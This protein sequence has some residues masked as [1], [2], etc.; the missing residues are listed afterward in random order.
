MNWSTIT[1]TAAL[2]ALSLAP[3]AQAAPA[4]T[5]AFTATVTNPSDNVGHTAYTVGQ[6]VSGE[7]T[8]YPTDCSSGTCIGGATLASL[9]G[10]FVNTFAS[11]QGAAGQPV[12]TSFNHDNEINL[13]TSN[14]PTQGSGTFGG[15]QLFAGNLG[16]DG[17]AGFS[18][19]LTSSNP[20]L[21]A[22]EI[23]NN[24]LPAT[25]PDLSVFDLA[26]TVSYQLN[27]ATAADYGGAA[28]NGYTATITSLTQEP[29]PEPATAALLL[30]ALLGLSRIARRRPA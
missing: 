18:I 1:A 27:P 20:N 13:T 19:N 6:A 7:F 10:I 17:F 21:L 15:F 24:I 4:V 5:Y 23:A 11:F 29:V 2:A 3:C 22:T 28:A 12:L 25:L 8:Y 9:G 16:P 30:P 26:A 14:N